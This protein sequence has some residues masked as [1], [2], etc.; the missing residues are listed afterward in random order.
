MTANPWPSSDWMAMLSERGLPAFV[1][2]TMLMAGLGLAGL[3]GWGR[4][5]APLDERLRAIAGA[6][7]VLVV[8]VEGAFDAVLLLATPTLVF[9]GAMG[10][11]MPPAPS[12]AASAPMGRTR[13][14]LLSV[15]ILATGL[16]AAEHSALKI[17]SMAA[18][19]Q[20]QLGRAVS[21]DPGSFRARLRYAQLMMS[22]TS[23]TR[24]CTEA[25]AALA[26]F[27]RSPDAKRLA[28]G[29]K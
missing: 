20:G 16:A 17:S 6:A 13:R 15:V 10:A 2:W 23:R 24:G 11:L 21:L 5:D 28:A 29:C 8:A 9:W 12:A 26:L 14:L 27:P 7:V 1:S 22:R 19:S 3:W 4:L 18:Y 25:K